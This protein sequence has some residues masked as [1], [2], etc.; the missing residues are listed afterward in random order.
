[1]ENRHPMKKSRGTWV[2][3][4]WA[5]SQSLLAL[6]TGCTFEGPAPE[7]FPTS[8]A[9]AKS[10]TSYFIESINDEKNIQHSLVRVPCGVDLIVSG[11]AVDTPNRGAAGGVWLDVDGRLY[12]ANY[13]IPRSDVAI[14][15]RNA[16]FEASGFVVAVPMADIGSLGVHHIRVRVINRASSAY[17]AGQAVSF[18]FK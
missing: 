16:A 18:E 4:R 9:L 11:W 1:M 17:Y 15:M 3:S 13:G 14:S 6:L 12:R 5:A 7:T 2:L 10:A 8:T